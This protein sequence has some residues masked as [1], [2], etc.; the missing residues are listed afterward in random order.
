MSFDF[1]EDA[2]RETDAFFKRTH[3]AI[4]PLTGE[5]I[6]DDHLAM[7]PAQTAWERGRGPRPT[8]RVN[9]AWAGSP[10]KKPH[11]FLLAAR[12]VG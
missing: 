5:E 9:P 4:V 3:K 12:G 2:Q 1:S 10:G 6:L 11:H 8:N 7:K